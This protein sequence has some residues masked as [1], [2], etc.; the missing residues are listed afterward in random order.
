LS[1]VTTTIDRFVDFIPSVIAAGLILVAGLLLA[2]FTRNLVLSAAMA[3]NAPQAERLG[4]VTQAIVII[5]IAVLAVEELGVDTQILVTVATGLVTAA[6]LSVGIA[7]ALGAQPLVT[8]ILAGHFLRQHLT[9]G[10]SVEIDGRR[11]EVDTIGAFETMLRS[12]E[13]VWSI[14]NRTLL[15]SVKGR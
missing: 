12:E 10:G 4:S 11:G 2:R 14:P 5:F 1:A 6:A 9:P 13:Q 15:D 3:A 7:L 8:H